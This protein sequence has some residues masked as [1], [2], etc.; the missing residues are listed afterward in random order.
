MNKIFSVKKMTAAALLI[1]VGIIIPLFMP[2]KLILEP[3]ASY[4]LASHVALMLAMMISPGLAFSV[5][6]GTA[7]GFL[8]NPIYTPI[9]VLRAA[10]HIIFALAG[11]FFI[12]FRPSVMASPLKTHV[13]SFFIA[14]LHAACEVV[15]VSFFFFSGAMLDTQ[16][17]AGF[18][19]SV[20]LLIGLGTVVHS[21][22]D[23]LLAWLIYKALIRNKALGELFVS[24][25]SYEHMA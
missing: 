3:A 15:I 1:A 10:S 14:L 22:V 12:K 17:N 7:I 8:L 13:F 9:I 11:A 18:G 25:R 23:F 24:R 5:A 6:A 19:I 16:Y 21:M 2:V 4:T 20:V